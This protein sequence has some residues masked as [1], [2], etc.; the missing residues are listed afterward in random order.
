MFIH[1]EPG[2]RAV[3]SSQ[4]RADVVV[5]TAGDMFLFEFKFNKTASDTLAQLRA[6]GYA[7]KY[8]AG[9][10]SA[11]G[12]TLTAIGVNFNATTRTVDDWLTEPF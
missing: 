5:G 3:H 9:P 6:N 2:R 12:K 1:S 7:D 4:G 8:R 11:S 10:R